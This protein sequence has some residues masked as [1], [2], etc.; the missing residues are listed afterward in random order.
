[1]ENDIN[2]LEVI[3]NTGTPLPPITI[4][5]TKKKMLPCCQL[6]LVP[7][8]ISTIVQVVFMLHR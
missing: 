3:P 4:T 6:L 8:I 5:N 7:M 2:Q 1:M